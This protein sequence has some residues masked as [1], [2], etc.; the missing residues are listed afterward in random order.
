MNLNEIFDIILF[1]LGDFELTLGRLAGSVLLLI[2]LAA[3]YYFLVRRAL[4]V[5]FRNEET[6]PEDKRKVRRL[7]LLCLSLI[8]LTGVVRILGLNFALYSSGEGDEEVVLRI[9]GLIEA[10]LVIQ[11]ARLI[12]WLFSKAVIRN[13]LR[14]RGEGPDMRV[15]SAE[16]PSPVRVGRIAQPLI[17]LL[18]AVFIINSL[19]IDDT[20]W[21]FERGGDTFNF[22]LSNLL[23]AF[24]I[25][26]GARLVSWVI[27]QIVLFGYFQRT[28]VEIGSQYAVNQ[29]VQYFIFVIAILVALEY[30]GVTLTVLWGGAAALLVGIGLGLQQTFNDLISGVILLFERA[31]E[32]GDV[33][34]IEGLIGTV[35]RIGVR[36]SIVESRDNISVIVPNSK[37]IVENVVNW[38]HNDNKARFRVGVGVAYGSDTELVRK[39]LLQAAE[40]NSRVLKH[41]PPFVRLTDFGDSSLDMELHFWS[42]EFMRIEN[43]K[44]ELRFEIDRLFREHSVTIP[45]PQRDVWYRNPPE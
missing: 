7:I 36:T 27:T 43:V 12:D 34:Q 4:P 18:V 25:L 32:V 16:K 37:L 35:R 6:V 30:I 10:L 24:A 9:S 41:P 44:S 20:L 1:N 28:R 31:V 22:T 15:P 38:S 39:L 42:H 26:V 11:A 13:Y 8:A 19:D 17:Y 33:V 14:Q 5:F 21:T 45:F 29:L 2:F 40:G 23:I 3:C